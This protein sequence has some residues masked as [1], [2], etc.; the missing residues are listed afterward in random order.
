M[1]RRETASR[2]RRRRL[3]GSSHEERSAGVVV[4]L[5]CAMHG[6][7]YCRRE[8]VRGA[9]AMDSSGQCDAV[10]S[11]RSVVASRVGREQSELTGESL[12]FRWL[13]E[14]RPQE[15]RKTPRPSTLASI[16]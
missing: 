5:C 9:A 12:S 15:N 10:L 7:F 3:V 1:L 14:P 16:S 13:P 8:G 6:V 11:V 4:E 2:L